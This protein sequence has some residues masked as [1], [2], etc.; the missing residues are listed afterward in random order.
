MEFNVPALALI[1]VAII[2]FALAKYTQRRS[3][4]LKLVCKQEITGKLTHY[5]D[6]ETV[7]KDDDIIIEYN[8]VYSFTVDR[9]N[10]EA[11]QTGKKDE[12]PV[13]TTETIKYNPTNP[14]EHYFAKRR[15]KGYSGS[16]FLW[17]GMLF[18]AASLA[19]TLLTWSL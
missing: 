18:L 15:P 19:T 14:K 3:E 13:G 11:R 2:C 4:R 10:Y 1:G 8:E 5:E 9:R 7:N 12:K 16:P 6:Y 17:L